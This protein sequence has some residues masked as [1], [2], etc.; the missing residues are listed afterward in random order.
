M[1]DLFPLL[2][3]IHVSTISFTGFYF[4]IRGLSQFSHQYWFKKRWARRISQYN[5]TVLL[6]SG[7]SMAAI[8]GQYPFVNSW[9]TTKFLLILVYIFLG[10]LSFYWL[11]KPRQKI[12][13]W[14]IALMVYSYIIGVALNKDPA[15]LQAVIV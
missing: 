1:G 5:D 9:L 8:I 4:I 13:A 3:I 6:L 11:Q 10:M 15:W 12:L 14:F 2:K 7:L